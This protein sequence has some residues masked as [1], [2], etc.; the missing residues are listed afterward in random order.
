MIE[1]EVKNKMIR[2]LIC[3]TITALFFCG[4]SPDKPEFTKTDLQ[5]I[6]EAGWQAYK[7]DKPNFTGGLA[8]QILSPKGDFFISTGMKDGVTNAC[9]FR[10]ASVTKTFTAAGI[11]LLHQRKLLNIDD[12]IT[13]NIPGTNEP[14]VPDTPDY[15]IPY[16]N[17]IT[18]RM[19]LM[20]RA[21]VFDVSNNA[22]PDNEVSRSEGY[23]GQN[24]LDHIFGNDGAHTFTFDELAGVNARNKL[25][26]F[27]PGTAYHYSDTGYSM[28][29]K[30]I[31]RVS[32]KTYPD[33]IRDELLIPNGLSNTSLPWKGTDQDLPEPFVKGYVWM[34]GDVEEVTRSN[35]SPHVAEGNIITTPIDL[36]NWCRKLLKGEAGLTKETVEMMKTGMTRDDGTDSTYGLGLLYSPEN[37]YGHAGAHEGYLTLM[38]YEPKKDVS[39]VMFTNMW[40]C[41]NDLESIKA[42]LKSMIEIAEE[43]LGSG[44]RSG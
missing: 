38:Y 8:M 3:M 23:A 19:L 1:K 2:S 22:I 7:S 43:V 36:V 30:I 33:F 28:L 18:I 9:H 15:N 35:M 24:Y 13:D 10:I 6:L 25:S 32:G 11:M 29:G 31:E 34:N 40:N 27:K 39:Y 21:G 20:H 42:E 4:C 37:G 14:Y 17:E 16:K 5:N 26:F 41:Q 44:E 12:K